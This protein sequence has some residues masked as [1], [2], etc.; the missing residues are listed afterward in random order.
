MNFTADDVQ[1]RFWQTIPGWVAFLMKIRKILVRPFGL[2]GQFLA[3]PEKFAEGIYNGK[4]DGYMTVPMKNH[5]ETVVKLSDKHLHSYMSVYIRAGKDNTDVILNS[6]VQYH[7][8]LGKIYFFIIKPL[9]KLV[10]TSMLKRALKELT[11][12]G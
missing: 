11:A 10:V 12:K 2:R 5:Q 4:G 8:R 9:H 1:A 6:T 3:S 7:N